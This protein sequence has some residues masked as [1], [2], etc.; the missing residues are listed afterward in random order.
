MDYSQ[1]TESNRG[2]PFPDIRVVAHFGDLDGP[3]LRA[4][5]IFIQK[6]LYRNC[7]KVLNRKGLS[8]QSASVWTHRLGGD[9]GCP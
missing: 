3:L 4:P 8:D 6:T 5:K 2:N 7:V 9:G 1:G